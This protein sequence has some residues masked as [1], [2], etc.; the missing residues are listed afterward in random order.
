MKDKQQKKESSSLKSLK[1]AAMGLV[2]LLLTVN[3]LT[4]LM[5]R[6]DR[7][8]VSLA[9]DGAWSIDHYVHHGWNKPNFVGFCADVKQV[10]PDM[11]CQD[12]A[13]SYVVQFSPKRGLLLVDDTGKWKTEKVPSEFLF[14]SW[15][16][17]GK[18]CFV[19]DEDGTCVSPY[20]EMPIPHI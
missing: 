7:M 9:A 3:V 19:G 17:K 6:G 2:M 13:T 10:I 15:D 12:S 16:G 5:N 4:T 18:N 14:G 20:L 8:K 11:T 1:Y